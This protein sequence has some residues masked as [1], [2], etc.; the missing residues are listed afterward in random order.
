MPALVKNDQHTLPAVRWLQVQQVRLLPWRSCGHSCG[1]N[2]P[3]IAS[4]AVTGVL[5]G[6]ACIAYAFV[7]AGAAWVAGVA[8]H[9]GACL[10][11][12]AA[13]AAGA[14]EACSCTP[15]AT[16]DVVLHLL[17]GLA[18]SSRAAELC[19]ILRRP[20]RPKLV[21]ALPDGAAGVQLW[22]DYHSSACSFTDLCTCEVLR[23]SD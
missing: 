13:M 23:A 11:Q 10:P 16:R 6:L 21:H 12:C 15:H 18:A 20:S 22:Q 9:A 7:L 1:C 8:V 17:Q 5:A 14:A 19:I 4:A 2:L 3:A